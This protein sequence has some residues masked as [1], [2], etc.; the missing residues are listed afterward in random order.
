MRWIL[1]TLNRDLAYGG[2]KRVDSFFWGT[3]LASSGLPQGRE[4]EI[5]QGLKDKVPSR[6]FTTPYTNPVGGDATRSA[7]T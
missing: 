1:K 2:L 7:T 3:E 4:L 5:L 6:V